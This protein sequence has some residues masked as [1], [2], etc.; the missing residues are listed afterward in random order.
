MAIDNARLFEREQRAIPAR[1]DLLSFVSHDLRNPLMGI[2]LTIE[3]VLRTA[4]R[5]ERRKG[6][7]QLERIQRGALQMQRMIDD[8]LDLA[9]L[10]AGRLIV[11]AAAYEVRHL[12]DDAF[13]ALEPLA[14]ANTVSL[15]FEPPAPG[16]AVRC[17]RARVGQVLSSLVGNSIKFTPS[18]GSITVRARPT[19]GRV[20]FAVSDTGPAVLRRHR[21]RIFERVWQADAAARKEQGLGLYLAKGLVE[22]QGGTIAVDGAGGGLTFSFALPIVPAPSAHTPRPAATDAARR[23]P[24]VTS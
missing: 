3:T 12:F 9:S 7:K 21:S 4:P 15:R 19:A 5:E 16:V 13:T 8:V 22:A 2:L 14:A 24:D 17:D 20:L 18:G 11:D 23:D 1:E 6:W 10:D